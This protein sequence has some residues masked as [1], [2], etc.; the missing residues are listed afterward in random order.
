MFIR[1]NHLVRN[2]HEGADMV[3]HAL[4]ADLSGLFFTEQLFGIANV[5]CFQPH[6]KSTFPRSQ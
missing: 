1:L 2:P 3:L 6:S 4:A 5:A